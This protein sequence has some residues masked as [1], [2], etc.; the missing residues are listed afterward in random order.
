MDPSFYLLIFTDHSVHI[1]SAVGVA[2][3]LFTRA[4]PRALGMFPRFWHEAENGS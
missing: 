1:L 4:S 3:A 2:V